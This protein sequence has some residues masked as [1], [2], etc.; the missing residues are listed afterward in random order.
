[1]VQ[2]DIIR[3][4]E[5]LC[6]GCGL[7]VPSCAEGAIAIV[8]GKAKLIGENLCDGLGACLGHCPQG[9][10]SVERVE[11]EAFDEQAVEEHLARRGA[12]EAVG[13]RAPAGAAEDRGERAPAP[14]LPAFDRAFPG[15]AS[16]GGCPGARAQSLAP[17]SA[18]GSASP[19]P[20]AQRSSAL[21]N[22]PVQLALLPPRA[23]F[24]QGADL[25]L[26]ADCAGFASPALHETELAGKALAIACPKLDENLER[27]VDKLSAMID[28]AELRSITVLVME[29]PCCSGL[30]GVARAAVERAG[31]TVPV[32][33]RVLSTRGE[34]VTPQRP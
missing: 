31:R 13:A 21:G 19:E 18:E 33:V 9:A 14:E 16:S 26:A 29:V 30:A 20:A 34:P 11:A 5:E 27:Y 1:M 32:D 17:P 3:I 4:E 2:R 28:Q 10:L 24:L 15:P 22:W 23:P 25:L 7:C 8:D 12:D 6:D